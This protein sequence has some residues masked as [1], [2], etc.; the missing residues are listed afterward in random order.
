[1]KVEWSATAISHLT[2]IFEYIAG[3][4]ERYALRMVDRITS[5]SKQIS[6]APELGEVVAE[7][8]DDNIRQ[9]IEGPYRVIYR[10]EAK[11]VLV[12]AVVH[13]ARDKPFDM[14]GDRT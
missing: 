8:K 7:F 9:I 10:I 2:D 14:G 5:R 12:L 6:S 11:S 4:S 3:D 13:G 1:M